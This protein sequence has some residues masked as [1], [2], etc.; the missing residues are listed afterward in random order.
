MR[1]EASASQSKPWMMVRTRAGQEHQATNGKHLLDTLPS[2]TL[3]KAFDCLTAGNCTLAL[4]L[5]YI[6]G[7]CMHQENAAPPPL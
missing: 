6:Q 5:I 3:A 2:L 7:V 4:P 1:R